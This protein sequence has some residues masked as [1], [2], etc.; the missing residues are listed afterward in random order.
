MP[1]LKFLFAL[2]TICSGAL[3]GQTTSVKSQ[4]PDAPQVPLMVLAQQSA[5]VMPNSVGQAATTQA[6]NAATDQYPRL[7]QSDAEKLAIKNNPRVSVARLLAL[8]QHQVVRETRAAELPTGTASIT[9]DG[10]RKWQPHFC[11]LAHCFAAL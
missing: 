5:T 8:A 11:G 1:Y 2:A 6:E 7:T 4:L 10:C 3:S 9:A